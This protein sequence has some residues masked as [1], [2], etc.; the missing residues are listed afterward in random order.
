MSQLGKPFRVQIDEA[1][2][3]DLRD[4]LRRTRW[5]ERETVADWS[6]GVPLAYAR[7]LAAYWAD[8]YDMR[9]LER[10]VNVH[11]QF[12]VEIGGLDIHVLHAPSPHPGALP[13]LLTHGWPGSIVEFLD[14]IPALTDPPDPADA[15]HVICPT[16]PGFGYSGKPQWNGW[17]VERIAAAWKELMAGLGHAR[18]GAQGGDWG[19]F[20]TAALGSADPEHVAG[21][22]MTLPRAPEIAGAAITER[23][24]A[25]LERLA[26]FR[27]RGAGYSAIQSTRPQTVGYGLLDSP[28]GEM[29]WIV[30]KFWAWTDHDGDLETVVDRDTMLDNV[31]MYWFT[32]TGASSAR[33]YWESF[34][35][36]L[37]TDPVPVPTGV[38]LFPREIAP[39][40]RAWAEQRFTD[41]RYWRDDLERGG[42]FAS[43][44]VPEVFVEELRTFFRLVR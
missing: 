8:G 40:P 10:R 16:L 27:A 36:H 41:I 28:V 39:L 22:H 26:E 4:R 32:A 42:H 1:D 15:F 5:P 7:D 25:G 19:S 9:R 13:L 2:I 44:E 29:A 30:D 20:V 43:L 6:Q 37:G 3:A 33:I 31:S 11:E 24:K 34:P 38:S 23:E 14:V 18:Y 21:I 12:L 35:R 17:N